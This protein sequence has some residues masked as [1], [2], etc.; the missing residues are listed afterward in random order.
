MKGMI[1]LISVYVCS[2]MVFAQQ[3]VQ[4]SPAR[5]ALLVQ[6][7]I[8]EGYSEDIGL[9][10]TTNPIDDI[11]LSQILQNVAKFF[12]HPT[13]GLG[14]DLYWKYTPFTMPIVSHTYTN[15]NEYVP[16]L[17]KHTGTIEYL[18]APAFVNSVNPA[19]TNGSMWIY[20]DNKLRA[21]DQDYHDSLF[22]V[23]APNKGIKVG[24]ASNLIKHGRDDAIHKDFVKLILPSRIGIRTR[25]GRYVMPPLTHAETHF[26]ATPAIYQGAHVDIINIAEENYLKTGV[27]YSSEV[28][29]QVLEYA[30]AHELFHLIGGRHTN[31]DLPGHLLGPFCPL[32][33]ITA[34][35]HEIKQVNLPARSS[36]LR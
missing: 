9:G 15:D 36:I 8:Q 2:V 24:I 23:T 10:N 34:Q 12:I 21:Y 28:F 33:Q 26:D 22:P 3:Y 1:L 20:R 30:F 4:L 6:V 18:G 11:D 19:V 31:N 16:N 7:M 5:K 35:A 13:R 32:D 25:G 14:I 29:A 17:Y 27:H